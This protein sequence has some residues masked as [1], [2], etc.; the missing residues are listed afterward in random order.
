MSSPSSSPLSPLLSSI[1][2]SKGKKEKKTRKKSLFTNVKWG[3]FS[4][5]FKDYNTKHK[6]GK[7]KSLKSFANYVLKHP[8]RFHS[9]SVKR[10]RF[11]NNLIK[12][13]K[14]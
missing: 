10:A 9:K 11:Y 2:T 14:K 1:L 6:T 5:Q 8:S 13:S 12:P 3:T 7:K 4:A